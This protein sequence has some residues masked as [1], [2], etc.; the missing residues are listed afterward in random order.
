MVDRDARR[1]VA[2]ALRQ[3]LSCR[4]HN[5]QYDDLADDQLWDES[6]D[7]GTRQAHHLAWCNYDDLSRHYLK[8]RHALDEEDRAAMLRCI[9]FM[10]SDCEYE[11]PQFPAW[12][13]DFTGFYTVGYFV[14]TSPLFMFPIVQICI[15]VGHAYFYQS[16]VIMLLMVGFWIW[17]WF[18]VKK[19]VLRI[20]KRHHEHALR[21][22]AMV[23]K[24]I[25]Q[26]CKGDL[27]LWPF[28]N[29]S[30]YEHALHHPR[31]LCGGSAA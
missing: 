21:E 29:R 6:P 3:F 2:Q 31:L 5:D 18:K 7:E 30:Q 24:Q 27:A 26:D 15:P 14:I 17:S 16:F 1:Q 20:P 28:R 4:M 22:R 11:W 10:H 9:L 25:E 13:A 19:Y 8:G 12:P 23:M